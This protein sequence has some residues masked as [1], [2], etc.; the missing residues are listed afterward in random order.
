MLFEAH[1]TL[2]GFLWVDLG[3]VPKSAQMISKFVIATKCAS[4][5]AMKKLHD[6]YRQSATELLALNY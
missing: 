6:R 5:D 1:T 4:A 2:Q 3:S